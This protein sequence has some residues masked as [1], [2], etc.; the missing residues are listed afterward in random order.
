MWE[1]KFRKRW[2]SDFYVLAVSCV[3]E[4]EGCLGCGSGR[5]GD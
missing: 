1:L 5:E 4:V 3:K 2:W